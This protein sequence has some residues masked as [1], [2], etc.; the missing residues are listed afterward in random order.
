MSKGKRLLTILLVVFCISALFAFVSCGIGDKDSVD[1]SLQ[2]SSEIN[3]DSS[4]SGGSGDSSGSS[5]TEQPD[6]PIDAVFLEEI[7]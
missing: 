2:S 7:P 6:E 5:G 1:S 3:D 4:S